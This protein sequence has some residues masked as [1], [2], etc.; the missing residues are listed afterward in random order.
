[1][2]ADR[3]VRRRA[4]DV[5]EAGS[6][7]GVLGMAGSSSESIVATDGNGVNSGVLASE[8]TGDVVMW[9]K[10]QELKPVNDRASR[11]C[12]RGAKSRLR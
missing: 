8:G 4:T 11:G 1:M 3:G 12:G 7:M 2:D 5:A 10:K 6:G 9:L